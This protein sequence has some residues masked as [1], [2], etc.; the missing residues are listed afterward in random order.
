[1]TKVEMVLGNNEVLIIELYEEHAP[2]TVK[3]F[4][5]LINK[6]YYNGLNFH[7]VIEGFVSQGGCPDG[8]G[9]G[10]P[11]YSIPCE[12]IKNPLIHEV[13]SLSM[14]HRGM[15]TGGSQFFICHEALPHLDGKHTV[16][17]KVVSGVE[18]AINMKQGEKMVSV[19]VIG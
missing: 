15:N 2:G 6:G 14:A 13:G 19:K 8:T 10:G 3:N 11:G 5:D 16:F 18:P 12:L 9:S 4:V 7:R 1:M 17:G